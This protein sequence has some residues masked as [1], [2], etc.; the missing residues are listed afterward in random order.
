MEQEDIV[1]NLLEGLPCTLVRVFLWTIAPPC[2]HGAMKGQGSSAANVS[3]HGDSQS[4]VRWHSDDEPLFGV[5]GESMLI[6]SLSL[7]AYSTETP[8]ILFAL[9]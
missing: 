7:G 4:Q 3:L 6:V 1:F 8:S 2:D 5:F 9:R